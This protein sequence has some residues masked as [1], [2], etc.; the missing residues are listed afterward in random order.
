MR[1]R[2]AAR[3]SACGTHRCPIAGEGRRPGR[4]FRTRSSR[5]CVHVED[6]ARVRSFTLA[7]ALLAAIRRRHP[8]ELKFKPYFDVLAGTSELR[9]RIERGERALDIVGGY[10]GT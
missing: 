5:A 2:R 7:V 8:G 10:G 4:R 6:A 3:M 1:S 9:E